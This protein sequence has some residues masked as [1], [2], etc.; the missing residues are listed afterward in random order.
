[1]FALSGDVVN[2]RIDTVPR[3]ESTMALVQFSKDEAAEN[4]IRNSK[5]ALRGVIGRVTASRCTIDV[6]PPVDAVFGKPMTVGRHVMA[7]S[8]GREDYRESKES[9]IQKSRRVIAK[10]LLEISHRTTWTIPVG[11]LEKLEGRESYKQGKTGENRYRSRS[12]SR[13]DNRRRTRDDDRWD[14]SRHNK[15]Y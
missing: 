4:A 9:A 5:V 8:H 6:I 13:S 7:T 10:V 3:T 11:E 15:D 1:M 14:R 2:V 12:R